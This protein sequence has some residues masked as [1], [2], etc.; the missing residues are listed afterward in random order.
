MIR[1]SLLSL[2]LLALAGQAHAIDGF[3]LGVGVDYSSG[4][5][6]SDTT[7]D[8]LSIP[9]SARVDSGNLSLRASLPWL[10]VSGDPNVLPATGRVNNLNPI[11]RGRGGLAGIPG[12]GADQTA[13]RGSTSG[14]GDLSLAAIYSIPT[15]GAL[16]VDLAFNAKIA[17]ADE[18]KSLGTGANDYGVA[19][20][21][22]RDFDGTMLFGGAGYTQLGDSDYI[23]VDSVLSGNF[24][25]GW[26]AGNRGRLG[27]MYDYREAA[28]SSFEDRSDLTGF[29]SA[30]ASSG[31]RFQLYVSKGLSDGS[32]DWGAGASFLQSF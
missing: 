27:L 6:G 17:T 3:S 18:D 13:E 5:Y 16:G 30:P 28:S 1:S 22:Y 31:G 24:G 10:H 25:V 12:G 8:I 9:L 7:T 14:I 26:R 23:E 15:G 19:I 29:F 4:E 32:P 11:G 2:A 20:D 21:L